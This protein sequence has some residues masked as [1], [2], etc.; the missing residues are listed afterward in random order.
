MD[1]LRVDVVKI[2]AETFNKI[3][4]P[5]MPV[6]ELLEKT[7]DDK[8]VWSLYWTGCTMGLNQVEREKSSQRCAQ[9]KPK[10]IE[11]LSAF[12][13]AI[14]PGFKS[15]LDTF[16]TRTPFQYG[17]PSLD[18]LLKTPAIPDSFLE[19]DEQILVILKAAGIPGPDAYAAIKAVKKKKMEKVASY[20]QRFKEGFSKHLQETENA[21]EEK[22]NEIVEQIWTIIENAANYMFC[23]AHAISMGC[24]SLYV[25]WLKAYYPYE[26]YTV[27]LKLYD[28]KKN[29]DKISAI[30]SEMKR[31]YGITM[32]PG[33]FGQDNRDWSA[34][35]EKATISQSISSVRYI[36]KDAAE[37]L[38][39]LG[40]QDEA[41]IGVEY[42]P[43][44][45]TSEGKKQINAIKKEL[46]QLKKIYDTE[47][48]PLM[49]DEER[50]ELEEQKEA[51]VAKGIILEEDLRVAEKN[52]KYIETEAY[53]ECVTAKLDCFANVLRAIQMNTGINSRVIKTL[54]GIGYFEKFGKTGK[55][56]KVF[57]AFTEGPMAISK[58]IKSFQERL[59]TL[60]NYEDS[61]P[62][63]ELPISGR[64]L[65][66]HENIGLCLSYDKDV[67]SR[68]YFVQ[69]VDDK[70]SIRVKLY[71]MRTGKSGTAR[72]SKQLYAYQPLR[73]GDC[74]KEAKFE[75]RPRY[76]YKN[77]KRKIIPGEEEVWVTGYNVAQTSAA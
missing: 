32:I 69:Q 3:G 72:I 24:D 57:D 70:Y 53:E 36:S 71:N 11:E 67:P 60:R 54:I 19:Y 5:V 10:N 17:I 56:M 73:E 74:I 6:D 33:R 48:D 47:E 38:Y 28:E 14:R 68:S 66:E 64:L 13:A 20:K 30:I 63:E 31:F 59:K 9:Y 49:S 51:A 45:Y 26:L 39:Q 44:T 46:R 15:M 77:G 23:A 37:E 76:S 27:M 35:K 16:I 75:K 65:N 7:K 50:E 8:K 42:H 25:A 18:N 55:L 61:L 34:N 41:K 52:P 22:A 12:V 40:L 21:T 4:L 58:S 29:K 2:I 43:T 62:D 1:F